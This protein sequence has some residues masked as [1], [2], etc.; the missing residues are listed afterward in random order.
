[1]ARL[2]GACER[3]KALRTIRLLAL[4][5][6]AVR[7]TGA[8]PARAE[9]GCSTVAHLSLQDVT[10]DLVTT[11]HPSF[12]RSMNVV[13]LSTR[14]RQRRVTTLRAGRV[15]G[16]TEAEF[17]FDIL[18][19]RTLVRQGPNFVCALPSRIHLRLKAVQ[20]VLLSNS[21]WHDPCFE[22]AIIEHELEHV[23][24]TTQLF[25]RRAN[26]SARPLKIYPRKRRTRP[27]RP[28]QPSSPRLRRLFEQLSLQPWKPRN[29]ATRR[30]TA[31]KH[32]KR[33]VFDVEFDGR[34]DGER[35]LP[36]DPV[37]PRLRV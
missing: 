30:S 15:S 18:G 6:V 32:I 11:E 28:T 36:T 22:K 27:R 16:L 17:G 10:I 12:D 13:Q 23:R 24:T 29:A 20:T 8:E 34:R 2:M 33:Y 19:L 25:V 31:H 3:M 37:G 7:L 1:M 14:A 26:S 5:L 35:G 21:I 4:L 9:E